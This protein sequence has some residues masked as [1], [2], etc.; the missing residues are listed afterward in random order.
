LLEN[1]KN[2]FEISDSAR[3]ARSYGIGALQAGYTTACWGPFRRLECRK[4]RKL[5]EGCDYRVERIPPDA[6]PPE[7]EAESSHVL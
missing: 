1:P 3:P 7:S 6:N 4:P 5:V 2:P